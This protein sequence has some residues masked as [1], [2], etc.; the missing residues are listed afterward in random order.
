MSGMPAWKGIY[1]DE[2][3]WELVSI[4]ARLPRM[5]ATEYAELQDHAGSF[6]CPR[7]WD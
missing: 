1:S 6:A 3:L 2:E 7:W 4:V 5:S